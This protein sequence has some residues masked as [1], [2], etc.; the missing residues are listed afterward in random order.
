MII[1]SSHKVEVSTRRNRIDAQSYYAAL[2]TGHT[3]F[4]AGDPSQARRALYMW[5]KRHDIRGLTIKTARKD[6]VHGIV[7]S[8]TVA[9]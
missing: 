1:E 2:K 6:G 9:I 7:A 4:I 8:L 3:V 5:R